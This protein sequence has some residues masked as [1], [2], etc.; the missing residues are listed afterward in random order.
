MSKLISHF[1]S[2]MS[3]GIFHYIQE[4]APWNSDPS[5][6]SIALDTEYF[7]NRSG[8]REVSSL[9]EKLTW[10]KDDFILTDVEKHMLSD[11]IRSKYALDW[12]RLWIAVNEEYKPLENYNSTEVDTP[13]V[14]TKTAQNTD[15]T[16][17]VNS[18]SDTSSTNKIKALGSDNF[19][20]LSQ[21]DGEAE[22]ARNEQTST[23]TADAGRN[24]TETTR[25]GEDTI[26]RSGNIGVTTSQ[27]MLGSEYE[28]RQKHN[29][30]D[31]VFNCVDEVLTIP[32]WK[33]SC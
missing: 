22:K 24:Y 16:S 7:G 9:V 27:Q 17:T 25:E 19:V 12:E 18:G 30:F 15:V 11:I 10:L 28:L 13:R 26:T 3:D 21:V 29:F 23:T 5:V 2:W 20:E 32:F 33:L 1:P 31:Y 14:K 6:S 8:L 4:W